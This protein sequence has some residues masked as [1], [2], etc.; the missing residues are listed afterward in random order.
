M[1][2][3]RTA[4][5]QGPAGVPESVEQSLGVLEEAAGR[6]AARGARVLVT[7]EMFLTG[8]A[9]GERVAELAETRRGPAGERVARIAARHGIAI[10]YGYPERDGQAVFNAARLVGPDGAGLA[11]YRKTHLFGPYERAA[12]TPGD[13][14]VV[15]AGL[16][17]HRVGLLICYDVEFPEAVRAHALAGTE[18]L[19]VPTALMRPYEFVSTT[20]V[21]TRAY[22]NGIHIAYANRCGPEGEWDFAG[23]SA[24]AGPDGTVRARAGAGAEFLVADADPAVLRAAREETPYLA[25]RRPELYR[26]H[27]G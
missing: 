9:V 24:L 6:A 26:T 1:T 12:F 5:L 21:P 14:Q 8:Y 20:L 3:L 10:A 11:D 27:L 13:T 17:G 16:D 25:D 22:E 2:P 4:L 15:Q 19:L 23:L 7:S 18:V